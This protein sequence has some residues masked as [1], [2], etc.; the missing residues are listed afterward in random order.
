MGVVH[1]RIGTYEMLQINAG[2]PSFAKIFLLLLL[3]LAGSIPAL[4]QSDS[5][6]LSS[7]S[8]NAGTTVSLNLS[9]SSPSGSQPAGLQWTVTYPSA[10]VS[11]NQRGRRFGSYCRE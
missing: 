2:T 11:A 10:S 8:A 6:T 3:V 5:L 7:G 1:V 4:G 9:L